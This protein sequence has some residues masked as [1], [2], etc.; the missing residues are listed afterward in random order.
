MTTKDVNQIAW[1]QFLAGNAQ[2]VHQILK[3]PVNL[4]AATDLKLFQKH[5]MMEIIQI[6]KVVY[7]I[8]QVLIL[9]GNVRR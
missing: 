6:T 5:A 3:T 4:Y 7:R 8:A 9:N 2:E 1:I